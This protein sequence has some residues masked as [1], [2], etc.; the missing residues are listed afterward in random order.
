MTTFTVN[1]HSAFYDSSISEA[2]VVKQIKFHQASETL[3]IV[4]SD[5]HTRKCRTKNF[6]DSS[7]VRNLVLE[8]RIAALSEEPVRFVAMG[9][10]SPN[11]W[12]YK[13]LS[14]SPYELNTTEEA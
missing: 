14:D 13:L 4:C 1:S 10:N 5:G 3:L 12:F 6:A 9:N 11:V 2:V 7:E 8:L